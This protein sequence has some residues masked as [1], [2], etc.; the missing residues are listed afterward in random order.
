MPAAV[1][2]IAPSGLRDVLGCHERGRRVR[3]S[4]DR[5]HEHG[6]RPGKLWNRGHVDARVR[7]PRQCSCRHAP[8]QPRP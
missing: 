8:I 4:R 3:P 7:R 5:R 2:R 6:G 1:T